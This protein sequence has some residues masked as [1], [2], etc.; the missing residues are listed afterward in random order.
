MEEQRCQYWKFGFCKFKDVCKKIHVKEE[1]KDLSNCQQIKSCK[2]HILNSVKKLNCE[3]SVNSE[4][5]LHIT[6]KNPSQMR[7]WMI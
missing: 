7:R 4:K 5:D 6:T 2:K 3:M 1:C